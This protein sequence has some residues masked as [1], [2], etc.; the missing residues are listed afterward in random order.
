MLQ[1]QIQFVASQAT[2]HTVGIIAGM[3]HGSGVI[4]SPQ[5]HVL[6]A[7]HVIGRAGGDVQ[8]ILSDGSIVPGKSLGING[9]TDAALVKITQVGVW[10]HARMGSSS[11]LQA[12]QWC[13]ATG[14]PGGCVGNR[15]PILR[16]GR[17]TAAWKSAI[18]TDCTLIGGDSGGPL[19]DLNGQVVGIHSRVG[20]PLAANLHIPIAAFQADWDRL[21][22]DQPADAAAPAVAQ[23]AS[24]PSPGPEARRRPAN[25]LG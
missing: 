15:D 16:I 4:V 2:A 19:L 10:P 22:A 14:H 6:T 25:R 5:G 9:E 1:R 7:A 11:G 21:V 23:Q 24:T 13:L 18:R 8:V 20:F 3:A 17:I 12:G